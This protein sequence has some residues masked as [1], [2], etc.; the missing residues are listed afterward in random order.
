[1]NS[2]KQLNIFTLEYQKDLETVNEG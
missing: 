2:M 1:M